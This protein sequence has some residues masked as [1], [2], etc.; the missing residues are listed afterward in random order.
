MTP[1][2][3]LNPILR[4]AFILGNGALAE[5][6]DIRQILTKSNALLVCADGGAEKA[7]Q[8]ELTPDLIIGDLDS[9][10]MQTLAHFRSLG[11]EI[12][13]DPAQQNNDLEKC[14]RYLL[15]RGWQQFIL[16][17]FTGQRDDQTIATLQITRKYLPRAQFLI[18][19]E[20]A[21]IFPL[22]K[23]HWL[24]ETE[25]GQAV[26]LFGFPQAIHLTTE[27]LKFPINDERLGS[28][29]HGLSNIAT[30]RR[31]E[32]KFTAGNLLVVKNHSQV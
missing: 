26:S 19:T 5:W 11:V 7:R 31:C 12:A 18:Y 14:L 3:P 30:G 8:L 24:I 9:I 28:G 16:A 32:I 27:G 29:S 23:G 22:K 20:L 17:G 15:R 25:K 10:T 21:E 4:T 2:T 1:T 6:I 13:H